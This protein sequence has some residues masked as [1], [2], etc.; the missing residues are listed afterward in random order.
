MRIQAPWLAA[1][2]L[3]LSA[4]LGLIATLGEGARPGNRDQG[5]RQMLTQARPVSLRMLN[6]PASVA[7]P[8]QAA[9]ETS[10]VPPPAAAAAPSTPMEPAEPI[11][12]EALPEPAMLALAEAHYFWPGELGNKPL[13][14]P[15]TEPHQVLRVPD[16]FPLPVIVHL[17]INEQ[18]GVDKVLLEE[19]FL[20][21][22]AKRF[23]IESFAKTR[24]QPG[25]IDAKPVKSRLI[26]E[27]RLEG[28]LPL[29]Q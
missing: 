29:L 13:L 15:E 10:A 5:L 26:L 7:P 1:L 18:G 21:E 4:H 3:S 20:S 16:V 12:L 22:Q 6:P 2:L 11:P 14:V 17:L 19:S 28:A 24:F 9:P 25:R 27:V 23:V 8:A